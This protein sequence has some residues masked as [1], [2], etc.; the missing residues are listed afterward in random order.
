MAPSSK[1]QVTN[2][3]QPYVREP[4]IAQVWRRRHRSQFEAVCLGEDASP[5]LS[6]KEFEDTP[7]ERLLEFLG[8]STGQALLDV[9]H[10]PLPDP[11]FGKLLPE[12]RETLRYVMT[13]HDSQ[14]DDFSPDE[15]TAN[16]LSIR[17]FIALSLETGG[18]KSPTEIP[19][20]LLRF[21]PR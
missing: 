21:A 16:A 7:T 3:H 2:H 15:C 5:P 13:A 8:I 12:V 10:I 14:K 20:A 17:F 4:L 6:L 11:R 19:L 9:D 18:G 1:P